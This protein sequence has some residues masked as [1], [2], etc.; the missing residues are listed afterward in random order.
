MRA[1]T[2]AAAAPGAAVTDAAVFASGS[3]LLWP[4][5][6][7]PALNAGPSGGCVPWQECDG[8]FPAG[9]ASAMAQTSSHAVNAAGAPTRTNTNAAA[10]SRRRIRFSIRAW[11]R[12]ITGGRASCAVYGSVAVAV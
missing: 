6:C 4:Q 2:G 5:A 3:S 1:E 8:E 11:S 12:A 10:A 7:T 9:A